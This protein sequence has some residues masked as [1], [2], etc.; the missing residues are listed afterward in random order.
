VAFACDLFGDGIIGERQRVIA[1][2]M[3]L[4]RDPDRL[5]KRAQ[6]GIDTLL[7]H[8]LIDGRLAAVGYCFG[9]MTV[10]QL[11]RSGVAMAGMACIHGSLK[12]T[13]PAQAGAV[14]AGILVCHGALDPHVPMS[15]VMAFVEEMNSAG[16]DWQL[17]IYGNARHGFTHE[18]AVRLQTPGV[19]YNPEA[20][21][22]SSAALHAFLTALF[23][24]L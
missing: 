7:S 12:T 18:D 4:N 21:A 19:E 10:L 20:D 11:A 24:Q 17:N 14:K 2:L 5:C 3:E 16:A 23:G 13:R 8:P 22:R 6:A 15:D 1:C 9:G